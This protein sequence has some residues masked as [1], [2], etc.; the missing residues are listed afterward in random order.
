MK[1][2][3]IVWLSRRKDIENA[4]VEE[5]LEPQK[6]ILK[7]NFFTC[8]PACNGG[9]LAILRY[10]E[11]ISNTWNCIANANFF[12]DKIK[13]GD[14]MWVDGAQPIKEEHHL[15]TANARVVSVNTINTTM[16]ITLEKNQSAYED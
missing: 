12:K 11:N 8:Q 2:G 1:N 10:G 13:M 4:L 7:N 6:I 5:F 16:Q 9:Y 14:L 3:S 15:N